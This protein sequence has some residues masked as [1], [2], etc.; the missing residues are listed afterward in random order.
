M[1]HRP[2]LPLALFALM[3]GCSKEQPPEPKVAPALPKVIVADDPEKKEAEKKKEEKP[4]GPSPKELERHIAAIK[5][6]SKT[7]INVNEG[8]QLRIMMPCPA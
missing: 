3:A 5:Q 1:L 2:L 4:R 7:G 8:P 6:L